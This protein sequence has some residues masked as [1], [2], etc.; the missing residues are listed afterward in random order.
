MAPEQAGEAHEETA[1]G[2]E[3][4]VALFI[5]GIIKG[6]DKLLRVAGMEYAVRKGV[7]RLQTYT[8]PSPMRPKPK[9][10]FHS[11]LSKDQRSCTAFLNVSLR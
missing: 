8:D 5:K 7:A 3:A 2:P 1:N 11:C 10:I 6:I 4:N 9:V